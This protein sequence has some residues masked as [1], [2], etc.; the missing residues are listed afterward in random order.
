MLLICIVYLFHIVY[1][2]NNDAGEKTRGYYRIRA[3]DYWHRKGDFS[4]L[5]K[6][7]GG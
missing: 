7:G 6:Y 4:E 5:L 2:E 3:V 1:S